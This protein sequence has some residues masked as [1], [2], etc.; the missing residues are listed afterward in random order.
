MSDLL[1]KNGRIWDGY[2]FLHGDVLV[3]KGMITAIGDD[4]P[5]SKGLLFDAAGMIVSPGL[6]DGHVHF[7]GPEPD[8]YGIDPAMSCIPF[9]V[10]AAIDAGG[11]HGDKYLCDNLIV[12]NRT[13]VRIAIKDD[14]ADF[15]VTEEKL[16]LYKENAIGI[17]VYFDT[18][19]P[20]VRSAKPLE[21]ACRFAR[22]RN[23]KVMV[24]C[25][26]A[27]VPMAE[28]LP[29]LAPGDILTHAFQGGRNNAMAD[30]FKALSEAKQRGVII[31]AGCAGHIHTGFNVFKTA[32]QKG[33][34]PDIISTDITRAS[35][36]VRGGRY[37]LPMCM[38]MARAAGMD[39]ADIY[40]AVTS[41]PAKVF[42]KEGQWGVLQEGQTAD[43]AVL[44]YTKEGFALKDRYGG[45]LA[46][47]M[48]YRCKLTV[49]D[50]VILWRD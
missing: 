49:A 34:L 26:D 44:H 12:K 46:S 28:Y 19:K 43:I 30:D 38:S 14:T 22:D 29:L 32:I 27:P 20:D 24:H 7:S 31:D 42:G 40:R 17:K 36:Y 9:G 48:G 21:Q 50:G 1:I 15:T 18:E 10:T 45:E 2:R 35:A 13:F 4:L 39:E 11:A 47:D 8:R 23:L 25:S 41:A 6:V 16:A 33:I 37:G 3:E 5:Y